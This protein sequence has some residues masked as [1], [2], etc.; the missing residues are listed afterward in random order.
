M[1]LQMLLMDYF[2]TTTNINDKIIFNN[3]FYY[4][5]DGLNLKK[6]QQFVT[7]FHL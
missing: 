3:K 1:M 2:I 6:L 7:S 5:E 4:I